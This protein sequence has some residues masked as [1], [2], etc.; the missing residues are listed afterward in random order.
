M[1]S[2]RTTNGLS[3]LAS[4]KPLVKLGASYFSS[5]RPVHYHDILATQ[6]MGTQNDTPGNLFEDAEE[7]LP[8]FRY[9]RPDVPKML[10]Y[11]VT[12]YA[13]YVSSYC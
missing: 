6:S 3:V 1:R 9:N 11:A 10:L 2:V 12:N 13:Y 7:V 5:A 8:C 4:I